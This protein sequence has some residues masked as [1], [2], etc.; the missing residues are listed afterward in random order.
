LIK[1]T[2]GILGVNY[3]DYIGL[4]FKDSNSAPHRYYIISDFVFFED[5]EFND[6]EVEA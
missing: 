6:N 5:R 4:Q 1:K 2:E 3:I